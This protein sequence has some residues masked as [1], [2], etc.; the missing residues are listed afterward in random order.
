MGSESIYQPDVL[1]SAQT[2][3][4]IVSVDDIK[5]VRMK[6]LLASF[7]CTKCWI[8]VMAPDMITTSKLPSIWHSLYGL[9]RFYDR[10]EQMDLG[11]SFQLKLHLAFDYNQVLRIMKDIV[12]DELDGTVGDIY[13]DLQPT[14]HEAKLI[15]HFH[16]FNVV[17]SQLV[18]EHV[19]AFELLTLDEKALVSRIPLLK[20][21]KKVQV[22]L[23]LIYFFITLLIK[24]NSPQMFRAAM[25][26]SIM[27]VPDAP[28]S[29]YGQLKSYLDDEEMIILPSPKIARINDENQLL[30]LDQ[31][32]DLTEM[33]KSP[34]LV[35]Q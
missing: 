16:Q 26:L 22:C 23:Q 5:E 34:S 32:E 13:S 31:P 18:A 14:C 12:L 9:S 10:K 15:L 11:I 30:K 24:L 6:V 25:E 20:L 2:A 27:Q 28:N 19:T 35:K 7:K 4:L 21:R 8:I 33:W 17:T 1:I 29:P 3:V